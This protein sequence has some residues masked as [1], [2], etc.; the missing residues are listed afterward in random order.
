[1]FKDLQDQARLNELKIQEQSYSLFILCVN[2]LI[3]CIDH[4]NL[5]FVII[6]FSRPNFMTLLIFDV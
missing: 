2:L 5:N 3:Q 4:S 6:L 1:L